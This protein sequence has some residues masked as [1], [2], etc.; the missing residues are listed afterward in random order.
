MSDNQPISSIL[1]IAEQ[2]NYSPKIGVLVA[3]LAVTQHFLLQAVR[4]LSQEALDSQPNAARNTIGELLAHICAAE[5]MFSSITF[6]GQRFIGEQQVRWADAF[7]LAGGEWTRGRP[8]AAY[9][10]DMASIRAQTLAGFGARDD[11]WLMQPMTFFG[12]PSNIHYYWTHFLLDMARHTGQIILLR[13]HL[14]PQADPEF[15]PYVF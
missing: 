6:E 12:K 9:M 4:D 15:N 13:K 5:V 3:Q 14:L 7:A 2:P 1:V 8:L 11:D 10:E